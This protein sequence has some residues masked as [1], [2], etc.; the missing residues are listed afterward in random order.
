MR[1]AFILTLMGLIFS[2][3]LL[4]QAGYS[5][6]GVANGLYEGQGKLISK[7]AFVPNLNFKSVRRLEA[8]II[9]AHTKAYLLGHVIAEAKASLKVRPLDDTRFELLDLNNQQRVC[10]QG[11]CTNG[12]CTFTA[13]VMNGE[14]TLTET[15]VSSATG[16]AV[17]NASQIFK[18]TKAQYEG[19]FSVQR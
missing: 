18:G 8:G 4:A 16:F 10:G 6:L 13:T 9:Q 11:V 14:L 15:W 17:I 2:Q 12:N 19:K 7:T 3:T 1:Q 5:T